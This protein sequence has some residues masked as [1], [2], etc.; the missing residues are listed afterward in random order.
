MSEDYRAN[1][2]RGEF[3][4]LIVQALEA[5]GAELE[6]GEAFPDC[7]LDYVRKARALGVV[8]GTGDGQ[9]LP[10]QPITRQ[11]IAV[12]VTRA[13]DKMMELGGYSYI[14]GI[15]DADAEAEL[16]ASPAY[17]EVAPWARSFL[18]RAQD[19][20]VIQGTGSGFA[21]L[22]NTTCEQAVIM[23]YRISCPYLD[24][25]RGGLRGEDA[26]PNA[27]YVE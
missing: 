12:M 7:G 21:P 9:Y 1:I 2:T 6:L 13:S 19:E 23:V 17:Q 22:E 14:G 20:G 5:G 11:E 18:R 24:M 15:N 8:S 27:L 3:A 4:Q 16:M 26:Y 25:A 10:D